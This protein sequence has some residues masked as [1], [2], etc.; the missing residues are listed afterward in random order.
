MDTVKQ[1]QKQRS[2]LVQQ[3]LGITCTRKGTIN[4]QYVRARKD[5]KPTER[6]LGPYWVLTA[7]KKGKTVSLRLTTEQAVAHA[8]EEIVNQKRLSD[9][10]AQ[11]EELTQRVGTLLWEKSASEEA[12]KKGLKSK[13]KK[14]KKLHE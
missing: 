8:R 10:F 5:G 14:T 7:K 13:S 12:L 6:L 2:L 1:L 9:L 11:F 3:M 4:K